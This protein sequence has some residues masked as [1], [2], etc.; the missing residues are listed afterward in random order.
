MLQRMS[1]WVILFAANAV[2]CV[3]AG[4]SYLTAVVLT[5]ALT[6]ATKASLDGYAAAGVAAAA[7]TG[8]AAAA[9]T[10]ARVR[11]SK[12]PRQRQQQQQPSDDTH[13][14]RQ[15]NTAQDSPGA[16]G[17]GVR[18]LL[19]TR[20]QNMHQLYGALACASL[21][22][23]FAFCAYNLV[24][25][26][27]VYLGGEA[28]WHNVILRWPLATFV[29]ACCWYLSRFLVKMLCQP[30]QLDGCS[31]LCSHTWRC[32]VGMHAANDDA[33]RRW[34]SEAG[35]D[36][37]CFSP[38]CMLHGDH[39]SSDMAMF[40]QC[41]RLVYVLLLFSGIRIAV[42]VI[43]ELTLMFLFGGAV[44]LDEPG[45]ARHVGAAVFTILWSAV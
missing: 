13:H 19:P 32:P 35:A 38:D 37:C 34:Q 10:G 28:L 5:A 1:P 17:H 43:S 23:A 18:W 44:T 40:L 11:S 22:W 6:S 2:Q 41:C 33:R 9:A 7:A 30:L 16:T 26:T 20:Q 45:F 4:A 3:T 14:S 39:V 36:A 42:Y 15:A 31:L 29:M 21:Q 8:A 27:V 24:E 25:Y 12:I